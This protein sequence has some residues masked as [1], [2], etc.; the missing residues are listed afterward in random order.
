M[1]QMSFVQSFQ[2]FQF[3]SYV[4]MLAPPRSKKKWGKYGICYWHSLQFKGIVQKPTSLTV[5]SFCWTSRKKIRRQKKWKWKKMEKWVDT[6]WLKSTR[7]SFM[8]Y[9]KSKRKI[10]TILV[11]ATTR[12]PLTPYAKAISKNLDLTSLS[13]QIKNEICE[14]T[15]PN[16]CFRVSFLS[17]ILVSYSFVECRFKKND[18]IL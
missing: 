16:Q 17:L 9:W 6:N 5:L 3:F 7:L 15:I 11:Q 12:F 10:S 2:G 18:A 14:L 8:K 1:R 13:N 4:R